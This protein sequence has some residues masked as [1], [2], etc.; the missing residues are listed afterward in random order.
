M[1]VTSENY[2]VPGQYEPGERKNLLKK[3]KVT[4]QEMSALNNHEASVTEFSY[5]FRTRSKLVIQTKS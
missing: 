4:V 2:S 3:Y 5:Y 1:N